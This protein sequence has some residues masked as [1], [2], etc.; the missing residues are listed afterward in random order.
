MATETVI[1]VSLALVLLTRIYVFINPP[2]FLEEH[3]DRRYH[4]YHLYR[5]YHLHKQYDPLEDGN[6]TDSKS[7]DDDQPSLLTSDGILPFQQQQLQEPQGPERKNS[8]GLG[9]TTAGLENLHNLSDELVLLGMGPGSRPFPLHELSTE[10]LSKLDTSITA[11]MGPTSSSSSSAISPRREQDLWKQIIFSNEAKSVPNFLSL[12]ISEIHYNGPLEERFDSDKEVQR[13]IQELQNGQR[14]MA[15]ECPVMTVVWE[16][17]RWCCLEGRALYIMRALQW[18]G[19]VRVRVLVDKDP[20]LLA[21]TEDCWRA[22]GMT[23]LDTSSSTPSSSSSSSSSIPATSSSAQSILASSPR[24][25]SPVAPV[26]TSKVDRT[27]FSAAIAQPT[28]ATD[29]TVSLGLGLDEDLVDLHHHHH[30]SS[31]SQNEGDVHSPRTLSKVRFSVLAADQP[32]LQGQL[33]QPSLPGS[34]TGHDA[35][36]EKDDEDDDDL[37][38]ETIESDGYMEDDEEET[39]DEDDLLPSEARDTLDSRTAPF[40]PTGFGRRL[41]IDPRPSR[42]ER[43]GTRVLALPSRLV[44]PP[45]PSSSTASPILGSFFSAV[46]IQDEDEANNSDLTVVSLPQSPALLPI[47]ASSNLSSSSSMGVKAKAKAFG[48][49]ES[50]LKPLTSQGPLHHHS[51]HHHE[52]K[53]SI[54][55]FLLPPPGL[56]LEQE[57]L[58]LDPSHDSNTR[59]DNPPRRD[60]GHGD[61]P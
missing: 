25:A 40:P 26:A 46:S 29:R 28:N 60:S 23:A 37:E 22:A 18:K 58:I 48:R 31:F 10:T 27:P 9:S 2:E 15:K 5:Q 6:G 47:N 16:G 44:R 35:D 33:S 13:A 7:S 43:R 36:D 54:P 4:E 42:P 34:P 53:I 1:Y 3:K 14:E 19:Q 39:E 17:G 20:T 21:V 12:D 61:T 45:L 30:L 24:M 55:E 56:A 11:P 8:K 57:Y 50:S 41:Q 32:L 52:R 49:Q 59:R 38:D 51:H